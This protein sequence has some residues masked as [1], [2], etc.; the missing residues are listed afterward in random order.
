MVDAIEGLDGDD[1]IAGLGGDDLLYGGGGK[2]RITG[3]EGNDL[4]DGGAGFDRSIYSGANAAITVALAA[5]TVTGGDSGTDTLFG[6][7]LVRGTDHNDT[8][9]ATGFT[10]IG[11]LAAPNAGGDQGTFNEFEGGGGDDTV[12]GNG[13]TRISFQNATGAVSVDLFAGTA[14]GDVSV[15]ADTIT[16]GVS[17]VRGSGHNDTIVGSFNTTGFQIFEGWAAMISSTAMAGKTESA[18]TTRT[19]AP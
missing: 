16:G 3:G 13:N 8:F 10:A 12:T 11:T 17:Q 9:D 2:D 14:G 7:E 1:A 5:G 4:I 18:T 15:G 6:V 19:P